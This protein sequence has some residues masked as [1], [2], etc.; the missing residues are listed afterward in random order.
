M[1]KFTIWGA[2]IWLFMAAQGAH[3]AVVSVTD[4]DRPLVFGSERVNN[5]GP[6]NSALVQL[7]VLGDGP[8]EASAFDIH[9]AINVAGGLEPGQY[10][11]RATKSFA[12][13]FIFGRI[14]A[15]DGSV[16]PG[17]FHALNDTGDAARF[18][19]QWLGGAGAREV[20]SNI[21]GEDDNLGTDLVFSQAFQP[22]DW[23]LLVIDSAARFPD[24]PAYYDIRISEVPG[25]AALPLMLTAIAGFWFAA[26]RRRS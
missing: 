1:Q 23:Y 13:S 19:I 3:A 15:T 21:H 26:T 9:G 18:H 20:E 4:F 12:I 17:G 11:F 14:R 22:S 6:L 8:G 5:G 10:V 25:P 7:G 24:G 2:V 16:T